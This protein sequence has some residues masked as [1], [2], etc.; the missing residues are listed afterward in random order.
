MTGRRS[1]NVQGKTL[2]LLM[3]AVVVVA[4]PVVI[5]V[6]T[7]GECRF[8]PEVLVTEYWKL[9]GTL[10][11]VFFG[12]SLVHMYWNPRQERETKLRERSAFKTTMSDLLEMAAEL[13]SLKSPSRALA[14][15]SMGHARLLLKV[16]A[17]GL[18]PPP[19]GM[20]ESAH[21][22]TRGAIRVYTTRTRVT[23]DQLAHKDPADY[24]EA[25][26]TALESAVASLRSLVAT[27]EDE[28]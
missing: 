12:F 2:L 3:T 25:E 22:R 8:A 10:V 27:L 4:I 28:I 7:R 19:R 18:V 5:G 21:E 16:I 14:A 17:R 11:T 23:L 13:L 15:E 6:V 26:W 1:A 24:W 20:T 9:L